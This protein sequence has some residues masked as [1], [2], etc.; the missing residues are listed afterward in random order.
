MKQTHFT[1]V[2]GTPFRMVV[3]VMQKDEEGELV[4]RDITDCIIRL[5]ARATVE[6]D[7]VLLDLSLGDGIALG[8]E[9]HT[10]VIELTSTKTSEL[11]WGCP[12]VRARAVFQCEIEPPAGDDFRVL[13][14]TLTLDPE[15]VR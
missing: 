10:F 4:P 7:E 1:I 9:D 8:D 6:S 14:G 3:S 5:Q 13:T 15:V 12:N 11:I 2:Q